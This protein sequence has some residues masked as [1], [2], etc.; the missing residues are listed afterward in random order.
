MFK[1]LNF[2]DT[3]ALAALVAFIVTSGAFAAIVWRTLR[4]KRQKIE[5]LAN[6][7]LEEDP[8]KPLKKDAE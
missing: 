3:A 2:D 6:L 7:P 8:P 4:M 1:D 5:H